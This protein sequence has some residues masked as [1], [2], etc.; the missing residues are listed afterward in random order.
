MEQRL[1][2]EARSLSSRAIVQHGG[3]VFTECREKVALV[4][5]SAFLK[6]EILH[7]YVSACNVSSASFWVAS[8]VRPKLFIQVA[9]S[10]MLIAKMNRDDKAGSV[11]G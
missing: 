10:P 4:H 8:H 5:D 7:E 1:E 9:D 11:Q 2:W 6:P 3:G